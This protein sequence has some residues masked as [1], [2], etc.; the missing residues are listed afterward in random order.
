MALHRWVSDGLEPPPSVYPKL[1]DGTLVAAA[2]VR[3][4][5]IPRMPPPN[6]LK[7]GGRIR[8]PQWPDGA[9]EGAEL[10][11]LVPQVD[12]DGNDLGG[13]R[14]PEVAVPLA[15]AT[16]WVF[17]P[18]AIGSPDELVPLKGA[19]IPFARTQAE[20]EAA[21]DPRVAIEERYSSKEAYL[22][23]VKEAAEALIAQRFLTE[24]DLPAQLQ[25]AAQR[26]DWIVQQTT[27]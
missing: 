6:A 16:G 5:P 23:K 11:L 12:A 2:A 18:E 4:P 13:I 20:R 1:A 17:R 25:Q 15:T 3:F 22:A 27:K 7:A 26:W 21:H 10:P 9:G 24:E 19:W 14:M 8:N